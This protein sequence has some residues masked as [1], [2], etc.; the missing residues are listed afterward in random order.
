[1][2]MKENQSLLKVNYLTK[3]QRDKMENELIM[4]EVTTRA[5][6]RASNIIIL[7][8]MNLLP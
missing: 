7:Y 3:E 2:I 1:M 4:I 8:T 5:K 6:I